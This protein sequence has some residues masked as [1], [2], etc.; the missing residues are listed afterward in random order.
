M[1]RKTLYSRA[2]RARSMT[3]RQQTASVLRDDWYEEQRGP[4]FFV[5]NWR[6]FTAWL[7]RR[8]LVTA[9]FSA[10]MI[11][12]AVGLTLSV[13]YGW[14]LANPGPREYTQWDIDNAVKN[15]LDN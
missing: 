12:L 1:K 6:R 2:K 4:G 15:T 14:R 13:L 11:L 3:D 10:A 5:T 9:A 7:E 8:K